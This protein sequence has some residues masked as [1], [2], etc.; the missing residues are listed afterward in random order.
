[1]LDLEKTWE[2]DYNFGRRR[3]YFFVELVGRNSFEF[4][5]NTTPPTTNTREE[6]L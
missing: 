5:Y 4:Q 6:Q 3:G 2:K 1:V